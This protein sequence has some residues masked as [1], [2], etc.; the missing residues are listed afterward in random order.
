MLQRST[1]Q[2]CVQHD[3]AL[4]DAA[5]RADAAAAKERRKE[6]EAR[7]ERT[8]KQA[9]KQVVAHLVGCIL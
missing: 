3:D 7:M 6:H 8:R 5:L 4:R 2:R 1:L 9:R